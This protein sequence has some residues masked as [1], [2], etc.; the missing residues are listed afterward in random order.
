MPAVEEPG[1]R[2]R[3]GLDRDVRTLRVPQ[4]REQEKEHRHQI[5]PLGDQSH[6]L[7]IHGMHREQQSRQISSRNAQTLQD[8]PEE[9]AFTQ[10]ESEVRQM[11]AGRM[12]PP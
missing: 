3:L 7:D 8:S 10:M 12:H 5:F 1:L 9:K 2:S 4:D 11:I 6:G